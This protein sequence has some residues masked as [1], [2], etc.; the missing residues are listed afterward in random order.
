VQAGGAEPRDWIRETL[1]IPGIPLSGPRLIQEKP[2]GIP[3]AF[4]DVGTKTNLSP[5]QSSLTMITTRAHL[6]SMTAEEL[7]SKEV[8]HLHQEISIKEAALTLVKNGISGAPVVDHDGRCVGVF[9]T[10]DLL[11]CY[12]KQ[13][14]D[15]TI[16]AEQAV[17]CPFVKTIRERSGRETDLCNLPLGVCSI[18]RQMQDEEGNLQVICS[19]PHDVPVEW[20]VIEVEKL[21]EDPVQRY[22]TPDPVMIAADATIQT[23]AR[24]MTDAHIHRVIVVRGDGRPVGVVSSSDLLAALAHAREL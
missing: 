24:M 22:M 2:I 12:S 7:M 3:F 21:P 9:S 4:E 15:R 5:G 19:Q 23:I 16:P 18:Q 17:T 11:R 8:V 1:R 20:G 6:L 13:K 14:H 10:S